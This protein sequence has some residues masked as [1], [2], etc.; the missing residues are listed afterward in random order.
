MIEHPFAILVLFVVF[1][2]L[3]LA[4]PVAVETYWELRAPRAAIC[5]ETRAPVEVRLNAGRAAAAATVGLPALRIR[6]CARWP[7]RRQC[8]Q[9]CLDQFRD[10]ESIGADER[11]RA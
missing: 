9:A 1:A 3:W 5:P 8:G 6:H 7:D 4:L 11:S 2:V 10:H